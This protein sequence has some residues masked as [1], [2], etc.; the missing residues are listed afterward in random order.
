M[1]RRAQNMYWFGPML[2]YHLQKW[3]II[4]DSGAKKSR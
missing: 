1:G 4:G 2:Y 3:H